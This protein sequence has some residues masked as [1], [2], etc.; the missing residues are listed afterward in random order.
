[1]RLSPL[2]KARTN[3]DRR[4][5]RHHVLN[6]LFCFFINRISAVTGMRVGWVC[7]ARRVVWHNVKVPRR[8]LST[9]AQPQADA[10]SKATRNIGIIAHIDAVRVVEDDVR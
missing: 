3:H 6:H 1:M 9:P 5:F 4:H 7:S 10:L 2:G 8:L